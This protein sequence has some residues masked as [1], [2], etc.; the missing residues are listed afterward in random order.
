MKIG[1]TCL[2]N[3]VPINYIKWVKKAG[4]EPVIID[5]ISRINKLKNCDAILFSG[6]GDLKY[7]FYSN[8]KIGNGNDASR[9]VFEYFAFLSAIHLPTLAICRGAQIVNVFMGGTLKDLNNAY[10]HSGEYDVFHPVFVKNRTYLINSQHH[11]CIDKLADN[12]FAIGIYNECI[13]IAKGKNILLC[14]YHPERINHHIIL[15]AL[16]GIIKKNKH[17]LKRGVFDD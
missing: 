16:K 7:W 14:Q 6:G 4:F 12:L 17:T 2:K 9:D 1:I 3:T 5:R 13:E 15:N 8:N 10:M 11:Q